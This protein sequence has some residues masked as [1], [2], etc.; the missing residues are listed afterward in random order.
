[1]LNPTEEWGPEAGILTP[2]NNLDEENRRNDIALHQV[3][4]NLAKLRVLLDEVHRR[5]EQERFQYLGAKPFQATPFLFLVSHFLLLFY[6]F[7]QKERSASEIP[8][9][10]PMFQALRIVTQK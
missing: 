3:F 8:R 1:M 10:R 5:P 4:Q 2:P 6:L 9:I 7:F